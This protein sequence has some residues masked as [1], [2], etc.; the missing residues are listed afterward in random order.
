MLLVYLYDSNRKKDFGP[1][2]NVLRQ[3]F[4]KE[5]EKPADFY[6]NIGWEMKHLQF[7]MSVFHTTYAVFKN[8]G[9]FWFFWRFI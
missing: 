7:E 5:S 4:I 6:S 3:Q 9:F 2:Y 1:K 8:D